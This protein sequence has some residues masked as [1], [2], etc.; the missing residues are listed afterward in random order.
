VS[1]V[2]DS[3]IEFL[4]PRPRRHVRTSGP[5]ALLDIDRLPDF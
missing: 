2:N 4:L 5:W 3:Y 1:G